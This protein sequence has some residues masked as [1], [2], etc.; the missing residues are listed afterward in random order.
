MDRKKNLGRIPNEFKI[1]KRKF[2]PSKNELEKL[3][4]CNTY[5]E[6]GRIFKVGANSIKKRARSMG[7]SLKARKRGPRKKV[8]NDL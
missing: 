6:I 1:I 2:D 3:I 7:I 4:E 8:K 5:V